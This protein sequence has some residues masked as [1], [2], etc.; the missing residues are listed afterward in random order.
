MKLAKRYRCQNDGNESAGLTHTRGN[1]TPTRKTCQYCKGKF[2][3]ETGLWGAFHWTG[4]GRY[5]E[6][7]ALVTFTNE[8][9]ADAYA[10]DLY[11]A[12]DR[13]NVV[14]RWIYKTDG[15]G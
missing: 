14:I 8:A 4:N 12:D 13:S 6:E 10:A 11:A 3:T 5:P 15:P 9:K 1:G 2:Y 7:A